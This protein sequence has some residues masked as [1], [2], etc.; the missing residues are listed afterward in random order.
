MISFK[1]TGLGP[2]VLRGIEALGFVQPTPIQEQ[3]IPMLLGSNQDLI[4]LAQTGTGKT[5][6][7]GLPVIDGIDPSLNAVQ[8]IVL[9][10]TRE[11]CMQIANDLNNFAKHCKKVNI[12]AVYGGAAIQNQIAAI[13][14]SQIVV[15]TPGRTLDLIKRKA[16]KIGSI[17]WLILD[18]ADEMLNMGFKEDLDAILANTPREKQT[19]LFSATMPKEIAEIGSK[20]MNDPKEISV[21]NRNTA[22]ENIAHEYYMVNARD[23]YEAVKRIMDNSPDIY[24]IIFCRTRIETKEIADKLIQDGYNADALHGDL[25][26]AQRDYVMKRFKQKT[27]QMLVATDVAARGLDVNNLTHIINYNL[28][29]DP[30]AYIHR[31]GRT[32]RAGKKGISISIIHTRENGKLRNIERIAKQ[33]FEKKEVPD[34]HAICQKQLFNFIH[35]AENIDPEIESLDQFMPEIYKKLDWLSKEDII[36]RF[37]AIE[38]TRFLES[39]KH[40]RDINVRESGR[41]SPD[42]RSNRNERRKEERASGKKFERYFINLGSKQD[43]T[44]TSLIGLVNEHVKVRNIEI[45]KIDI[46]KKFSFF[47][48]EGGHMRSITDAFH[49]TKYKDI[50]VHVEPSQK[51]KE[52]SPFNPGF[53]ERKETDFK[54]SRTRIKTRTNT[55]T[56]KSRNY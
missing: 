53:K 43:L 48:V 28:P 27:L 6:A 31:S 16:L 41:N 37:M 9:C 2:D 33:K 54:R 49:N 12:A 39:Y 10:P 46:M 38:F 20:Y 15:G 21:G 30:E 4:A 7:F 56:K 23:K 17:R 24:G 14:R 55:G 36:K 42:N 50:D 26:Q 45:G 35:K 34:A 11:L 22:H 1:E 3:T 8:A 44:P 19:L 51:K 5:A 25:S 18:E 13:K 29:D 32:G 52:T 47:E 40:S